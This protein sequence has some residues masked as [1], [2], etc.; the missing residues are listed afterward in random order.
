MKT[1]LILVGLLL[2]AGCGSTKEE[3]LVSD[4]KNCRNLGYIGAAVALR[5]Y[6]VQ[7]QARPT[8]V[9]LVACVGDPSE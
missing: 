6:T 2:L 1:L 9:Y 4:I 5:E 8:K 3:L 7:G